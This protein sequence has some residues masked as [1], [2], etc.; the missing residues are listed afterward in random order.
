MWE[1]YSLKSNSW[2]KLDVDIPTGYH[3]SSEYTQMECVIGGMDLMIAW[4]HL[5]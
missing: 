3:H 5:T 4:S 1:V 2:E